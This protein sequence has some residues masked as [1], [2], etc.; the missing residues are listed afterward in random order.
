MNARAKLYETK[1]QHRATRA[2]VRDALFRFLLRADRELTFGDYNETFFART[3]ALVDSRLS[4]ISPEAVDRFNGAY[5]RIRDGDS[6]SLSQSAASC[7]RVLHALADAACPPQKK[8]ATGPDGIS[9]DLTADKY[10]NRLL[11]FVTETRGSHGIGPLLSADIKILA[12]RLEAVDKI[13]GKGVH[14]I[15]SAQE[16]ETLAIHVYV[17]AAEILRLKDIADVPLAVPV[18]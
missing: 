15:V 18:T 14:A 8:P 6:E 11:W 1:E 7:R 4:S 16:A 17:I 13:G 12:D 2:K 5:R 9:R 3:K 10:M